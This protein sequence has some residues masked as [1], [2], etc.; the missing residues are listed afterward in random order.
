LILS[1]G[2]PSKSLHIAGK[3]VKF[4]FIRE[5]F[6]SQRAQGAFGSSN[7]RNASTLRNQS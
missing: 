7:V 1:E 5:T 4:L 3:V 6:Q 2:I